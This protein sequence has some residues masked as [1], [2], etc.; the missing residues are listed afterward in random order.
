MALACADAFCHTFTTT[1]RRA[2]MT[3]SVPRS[4]VSN[5]SCNKCLPAQTNDIM[6]RT[7]GVVKR[8]NFSD[9]ETGWTASLPQGQ[10]PL[11]AAVDPHDPS[12]SWTPSIVDRPLRP[13]QAWLT[14]LTIA[15]NRHLDGQS[16]SND[17]KPSMDLC[18][19]VFATQL[20]T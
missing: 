19:Q 3:F 16:S 13:G 5:M 14:F 2:Q 8:V 10:Y 6:S 17:M 1:S 4:A 12:Y 15:A 7:G 9:S 11:V 20:D 18:L